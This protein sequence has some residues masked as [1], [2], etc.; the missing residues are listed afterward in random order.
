[1]RRKHMTIDM[2]C[3]M[4]LIAVCAVCVL[5]SVNICEGDITPAFILIPVGAYV[6]I[7][8]DSKSYKEETK[9]K[10]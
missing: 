10:K 6:L 5:V 1:M 2:L 3:G 7:G 4:A 8:D 9:R